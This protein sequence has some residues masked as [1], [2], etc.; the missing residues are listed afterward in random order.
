L[1]TYFS[2]VQCNSHNILIIMIYPSIFLFII[3]AEGKR[4]SHVERSVL[5]E[6]P[7][8]TNFGDWGRYENCSYGLLVKGYV[9]TI[10]YHYD[11]KRDNSA[12]NSAKF[13]CGNPIANRI[14]DLTSARGPF[15]EE[16]EFM[17]PQFCPP[18]TYVSGFQLLSQP[19]QGSDADDVAAINL[20]LFCTD[21]TVLPGYSV[22]QYNDALHTDKR[23]CPSGF[24]VCGLQTQ[25]QPHQPLG[26][27]TALNNVRVLCCPEPKIFS[28]LLSA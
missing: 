3:V 22:N 16:G 27:D 10:E 11:N 26:D 23:H 21:G 8:L 15:G 14:E 7:K 1:V 25:V 24:G 28:T 12:L 2:N 6:S 17:E 19:D 13:F 5:L 9:L 20:R 18:L 4:V